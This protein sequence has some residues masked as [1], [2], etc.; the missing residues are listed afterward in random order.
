MAGRFTA[1][2]ES[3]LPA[4]QSPFGKIFPPRD[5][6]PP[7]AID[8]RTAALRVLREYITNQIFYREMGVG[9][10]PK[11][12]QIG[13]SQFEIE[14]NDTV[15]DYVS[16]S[17]AII[18]GDVT[19]DAIGL[20]TYIEEETRDLY[21][22]GTVLQWQSEYTE[23]IKMEI[24]CAYKSERRGMLTALETCLV[25]TEQMYGVRFKMPEYYEELVCFSLMRRGLDEGTS[26]LN[27]RKAWLEIE[28]RF[29]V[30]ALVNYVPL[31]PTMA[32][33]T[34]VVQPYDVEVDLQDPNNTRSL[35]SDE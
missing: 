6:P 12:F 22:P 5:N 25:P 27:R 3:L 20:G 16:P 7:L 24:T 17:I 19:Y 29:N 2:L 8:G 15:K 32:V 30:V 10:P 21:S 34:D 31:F 18:P 23:L 1:H 11:A 35:T 9:R 14:Q 26:H 4:N 28:M 33:N 13:V